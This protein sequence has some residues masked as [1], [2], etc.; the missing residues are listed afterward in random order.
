MLLNLFP[1]PLLKQ[2]S[3]K[4]ECKCWGVSNHKVCPKGVACKL[5]QSHSIL[6]LIFIYWKCGAIWAAWIVF[7]KRRKKFTNILKSENLTRKYGFP[8]P[9][10]S[11]KNWQH[12]AHIPAWRKSAPVESWVQD[13]EKPHRPRFRPFRPPLLLISPVVPLY[14]LQLQRGILHSCHYSPADLIYTH[15]VFIN[16]SL[17]WVDLLIFLIPGQESIYHKLY[18][19]K[20]LG[21]PF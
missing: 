6:K 9:L 7:L 1:A 15:L 13:S 4:C 20:L 19:W 11:H 2:C 16:H 8:A 17:S 18:I 3:V 5:P 14:P 10:I 12:R 21:C